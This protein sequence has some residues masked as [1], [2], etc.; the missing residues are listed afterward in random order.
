MPLGTLHVDSWNLHRKD[1]CVNR[2]NYSIMT[3]DVNTNTFQRYD[4][5]EGTSFCP[6]GRHKSI[7]L[8][9]FAKQENMNKYGHF[10]EGEREEKAIPQGYHRCFSSQSLLNMTL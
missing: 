2:E 6:T 9:L 5:T 4:G 10:T 3:D 8:S 1:A 7:H